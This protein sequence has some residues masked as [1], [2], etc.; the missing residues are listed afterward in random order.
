MPARPQ[1]AR[2]PMPSNR[3]GPLIEARR[4]HAGRRSRPPSRPA[5]AATACAWCRSSPTCSTTPPS[6]RPTAA[7]HAARCRLRPTQVELRVRDNGI[8]IARRTAAARLRPVH[9][10]RA[11]ARPLAGRA[12]PGPGAGQEPGRTARRQRHRRT[13]TA[14]GMGSDFTVRLP[15][16]IRD[17]PK[18]R[19]CRGAAGAAAGAPAQDMLVDDN[20]DAAD[21][22]AAAGKL[23]H[24]GRCQPDARSAL[25]CWRAAARRLPLDIGLPEMDGYELA[26]Q[27]A[28]TA[29]RPRVRCWRSPATARTGTGAKRGRRV[30][31]STSSSRSTS[32]AWPRCWRSGRFRRRSASAVP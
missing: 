4:H 10:G 8:G 13:A 31:T 7:S 30:S 20:V 32:A 21:T 19:E 9:P 1:R 12:G 15:R 24:T 17:R 25:D 16:P 14:P 11:L 6:T 3:C 22:L 29:R 23:G 26:R 18:P 28:R 5:S 27:R 2:R